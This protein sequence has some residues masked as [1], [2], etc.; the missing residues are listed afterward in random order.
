M[1]LKFSS[2]IMGILLMI[3]LVTAGGTVTG[4]TTVTYQAISLDQMVNETVIYDYY[5]S[6]GDSRVDNYMLETFDSCTTDDIDSCM[7]HMAGE[8]DPWGNHM[9]VKTTQ[10]TGEYYGTSA[11]WFNAT[12]GE[13][14]ATG[15]GDAILYVDNSTKTDNVATVEFDVLF[16][17]DTEAIELGFVFGSYFVYLNSSDGFDYNWSV[18]QTFTNPDVKQTFAYNISRGEWHHVIISVVDSLIDGFELTFWI[19]NT[20]IVFSDS[21]QGIGNPDFKTVFTALDNGDSLGSDIVI[22]NVAMYNGSFNYTEIYT[23]L[24]REYTSAVISSYLPVIIMLS[25]VGILVA[26]MRKAT[27]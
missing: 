16:E 2:G 6:A 14:Y 3:A 1:R 5:N 4:T 8:N 10:T 22:D 7:D 18:T 21:K 25:F 19:G 24:T 12:D 11:L 23:A 20:S 15:S 26:M 27:R 9:G 13:T 17:S